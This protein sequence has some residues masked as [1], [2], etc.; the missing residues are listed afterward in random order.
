MNKKSNF[1]CT[2]VTF[3]ELL[4]VVAVLSTIAVVAILLINPKKQLEKTRDIRK[5]NDIAAISTSF[6]EYHNDFGSY[7]G[8]E[9]CDDEEQVLT[10]NMCACHICQFKD[11]SLPSYLNSKLCS[12][13]NTAEKYLYTYDC[14][15][16]RPQSYQICGT[17]S[18]PTNQDQRQESV[19]N[20]GIASPNKKFSYCLTGCL[21][22]D[23]GSKYCKKDGM[24]NI[25]GTYEDCI[26]YSH[27]DSPLVLY[28]NAC[29]QQCEGIIEG[30]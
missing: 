14:S 23:E 1:N 2:G 10:D 21:S 7:P 6:E 30:P 19:Y 3:V 4:I 9:V 15:T 5:K 24:C 18:Y 20:F 8:K 26:L 17:L 25:C 11:G 29:A 16:E 13:K 22:D 28:V 12:I 27:C